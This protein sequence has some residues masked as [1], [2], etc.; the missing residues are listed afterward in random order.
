MKTSRR[1]GAALAAAGIATV[2][3]PGASLARSASVKYRGKTREGNAISFT[4]AGSRV[5]HLSAYVPTLCLPTEGA[6][7]SGADPFD[8]P[9]R[10]RV[11]TTG[12]ATAK[13]H[14]AIWNSADVTKNFAVTTKR[15]RTGRISGKLHVDYSFL[16]ILYTYPISSRPYVCTGDTTFQLPAPK[17]R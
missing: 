12:K 5:T 6:P 9:G 11:G 7:L 17:N 16:M 14:N 3:L 15:N 2:L 10:F 8:P 4:V 13:R 1:L